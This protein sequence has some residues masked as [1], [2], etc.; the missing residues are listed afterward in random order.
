MDINYVYQ[1][2]MPEMESVEKELIR[3]LDSDVEMVNEVASYV[4]ESGGKRLRPVFMVLAS[5]LCG[6]SGDRATVLSGVVEYIHTATLLHDDVIDGAKYRRG[7]KSA[8]N[9][10][11][12][13]ITV[14]C[15]DFLYSRAFINLVKDGDARV[16]MIL[17]NAAKTMSEGEVFQLV[18][19]AEFSLKIE[20]YL[21]IIFSKTAVLFSACCEI[22]GIL[23]GLED[24]KVKNLAEFGKV[25]GLAFQ[26][27]DDILDYLGDPEKTGKK[28][29]TDLNEG[30]M[31]LPL[32]LLRDMADKNEKQRLRDIIVSENASEEDL[33]YIISLM[34]KY[35]IKTASE[36][37]VD[38]YVN[39]SKE[40]L[41]IFPK[42]EYRDAL[43][44]LAEYVIKR[45][46]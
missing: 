21:K 23:G 11:G 43:E 10:F 44:F 25:V 41:N 42:N 24:E 32:I 30:K 26:M 34:K 45:D 27:S 38:D 8:N 22:G 3:N 4:F 1:M 31:T 19:T 39:K 6:Y 18:K 29:G 5:K 17:A 13:D 9:V 35:D 37:Y 36:R 28:P 33:T 40:L 20:D 2:I 46:R 15:G 7:R 12:N 14:L 16:Q